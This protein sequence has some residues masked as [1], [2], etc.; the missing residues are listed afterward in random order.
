VIKAQIDAGHASGPTTAELEEIR[1]LKAE[2]QDLNEA[3]D[4]LGAASI[5]FSYGS[6]TLATADLRIHRRDESDRPRS[7]ADLRGPA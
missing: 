2:N 3:N 7:R 5:F 4:I 6:S 1:R